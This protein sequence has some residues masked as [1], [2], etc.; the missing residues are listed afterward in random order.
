MVT[1][2]SALIV[3]ATEK[4]TTYISDTL[5]EFYVKRIVCVGTCGEARRLLP[6]Q[7][8]DLVVINSPL[9]D[10]TGEKLSEYIATRNQS[11]VI[12]LV[13]AELYEAVSEK[14]EN[15]GVIA[16]A[17]PINKSMFWFSLKLAKAAQKRLSMMQ[18]E[19]RKLVQRI[20]D[21][22]IVDRAKHML[23]SYLSM[24]EEEAHKYIERQAMDTRATKRSI[25]EEIL[26][27][28]EIH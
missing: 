22:K 7:D 15:H 20:E 23:I 21:I 17:K 14:V 10:E 27:I 6:Q 18:A 3:S 8:F 11:Q 24:S 13:K 2:E 28:Y 12:I 4:A 5:K 19:K 1:I 9:K 16:V 26:K 25:A